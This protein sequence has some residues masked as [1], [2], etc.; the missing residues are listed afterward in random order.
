[1]DIKHR[2]D[3]AFFQIIRLPMDQEKIND[4][5]KIWKNCSIIWQDMSKEDVVCRRLGK[6]T[7]KYIEL[8]TALKDGLHLLESY[9]TFATLIS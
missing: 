7:V 6:K 8:E 3:E 1:M 5:K 4:L 2:L 9:L